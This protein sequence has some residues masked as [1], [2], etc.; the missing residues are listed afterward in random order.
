MLKIHQPFL[1]QPVYKLGTVTSRSTGSA[2]HCPHILQCYFQFRN[3]FGFGYSFQ[4]S[5]MHC[6]LDISPGDS[7]V[8]SQEAIV[9][10]QSLV[11]S[12]RA[13]IFR[14]VCTVQC[15]QSFM[16]LAASATPPD[17]SRLQSLMD[18]GS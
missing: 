10:S 12:S 5:F 7:N 1:T 11:N 16:H 15:M 3:F 4:K 6:F 8:G 18:S 2:E 9:P 17:S 13:S 14:D